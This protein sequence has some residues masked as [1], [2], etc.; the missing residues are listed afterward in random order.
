M[1]WLLTGQVP[2]LAQLAMIMSNGR[3]KGGAL[4]HM[5]QN[6]GQLSQ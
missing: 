5:E 1:N 6:M 2:T 4:G 3:E